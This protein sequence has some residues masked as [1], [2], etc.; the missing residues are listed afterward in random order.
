MKKPRTYSPQ[1]EEAARLLGERIRE[2]RLG[3][4]WTLKELAERTGI[5]HVTMRKVER[6]D[7]TVGVGPAFEAAVLVGVPL[8]HADPER[9]RLEASD[10]ENRLAL[11]P[12]YARRPMKDGGNDF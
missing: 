6:G 7:L 10:V 11:L 12:K 4:R 2:A 9:R 1:A 3:R 8:F 5:N